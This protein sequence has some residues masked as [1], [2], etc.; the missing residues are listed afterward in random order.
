MSAY[1]QPWGSTADE[2]R[3]RRV[4][5]TLT[6]QDRDLLGLFAHGSID[7]HYPGVQRA[8][9]ALKEAL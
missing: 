9:D 8:L 1:G 2:R 4:M 7:I 6:Q 3:V 5:G